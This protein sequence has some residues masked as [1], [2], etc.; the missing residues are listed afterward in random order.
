MT[1]ALRRARSRPGAGTGCLRG[2]R[3][4]P[5]SRLARRRPLARPAPRRR[6]PRGS[7]GARSRAPRGGPRSRRPRASARRAGRPRPTPPGVAAR[8]RPAACHARADTRQACS[9][10]KPSFSCHQAMARSE[11]AAWSETWSSAS[12]S[13]E[14][15]CAAITAPPAKARR[16]RTP[17]TDIAMALPP[18]APSVAPEPRAAAAGAEGARGVP[19]T[20]APPRRRRRY[21]A[22]AGA[23]PAR[24]RTPRSG[25]RG[26]AQGREAGLPAG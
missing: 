12:R 24:R 17:R 11:S 10:R 22:P 4:A 19:A 26:S 21:R 25:R 23:A 13:G 14:T 15:A 3:S 7:G 5:R 9:G 2:R 8:G 6:P 18:C 16:C 20:P 1:C